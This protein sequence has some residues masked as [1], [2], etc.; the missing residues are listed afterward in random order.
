MFQFYGARA[1]PISTL[2]RPSAPAYATWTAAPET[3]LTDTARA[4][5]SA[6]CDWVSDC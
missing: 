6:S 2:T 5:S 3:A 1:S 4:T